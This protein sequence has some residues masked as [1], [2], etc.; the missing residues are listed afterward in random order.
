MNRGRLYVRQG[1]HQLA[2]EE[3]KKALALAETSSYDMVRQETGTHALFAIGVAYWNM[4]DYKQALAW[5]L[6]AQDLQ[7]KSARVW[8]PSLDQEVERVRSLAAGQP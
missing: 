7:R 3:F 4:H 6:K 5:L 8:L 1:K 2:I